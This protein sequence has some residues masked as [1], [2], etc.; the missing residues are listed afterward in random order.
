MR[1]RVLGGFGSEQPCCNLT[2]FLLNGCVMLDAGTISTGLTL[3]EMTAITHVV[4]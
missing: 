4:L 1:I 3:A 2:G